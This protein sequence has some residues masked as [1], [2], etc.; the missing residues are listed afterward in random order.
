M[1]ALFLERTPVLSSVQKRASFTQSRREERRAAK[2]APS[3]QVRGDAVLCLEFLKCYVVRVATSPDVVS[4]GINGNGCFQVGSGEVVF[5]VFYR[6]VS[7][8]A[9]I[10]RRV[11]VMI[12]RRNV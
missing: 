4:V 6:S 12:D 1:C 8:P 11:G 10:S 5:M 7:S 3:L 9:S 2:L